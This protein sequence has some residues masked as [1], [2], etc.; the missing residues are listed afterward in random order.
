MSQSLDTTVAE[1][2]RLSTY[3]LNRCIAQALN[4]HRVR[5]LCISPE[6]AA[7]AREHI[8]RVCCGAW[9]IGLRI[10]VV[11]NPMPEGPS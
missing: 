10:K 1:F 3:Q 6:A 8:D 9:P 7:V 2:L 11:N 5:Y 4:G